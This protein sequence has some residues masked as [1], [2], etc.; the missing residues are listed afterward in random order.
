VVKLIAFFKRLPGTTVDHFQNHWRTRHA[1][2]VVRQAGLRRYVQNHVLLGAYRHA[3]PFA[4]GVAEAWFDDVDAMRGLAPSPEY[5]AVRADE[6][7]FLDVRSMGVVLVDERCI[8]DGAPPPGAVKSITFLRKRADL[9]PEQFRRCWAD[10]HGPL[11]ARVPGQ[12]RYVQCP[13]RAGG[14]RAGRAPAFDGVALGWFDDT[15]ALRAVAASPELA[16]MRADEPAFVAPGELPLV[17]AREVEIA[18][19]ERDA[20]R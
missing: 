20:D 14:Y 10:L 3:E 19:R 11:A 4:D 9:S 5:A 1:G 18:C 13:A 17:F 16:A 7:N 8:V 2:L 12:R 15:A 6:A